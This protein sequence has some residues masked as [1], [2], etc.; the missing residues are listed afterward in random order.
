MLTCALGTGVAVAQESSIIDLEGPQGGS[1]GEVTP[2]EDGSGAAAT[3]PPACGRRS[4]AI[5]QLPWPSASLLAEI[6][7]R[8]LSSSFGCDIAVVGGDLASVASAMGA[9]GQPDIVPELWAA[10]VPEIWNAA[11][12]AQQVRQ[13]GNSYAE[14]VF[15][16][17]FVPDYA[18]ASWPEI[19]TIEGLR[20]RA[21]TLAAGGTRPRFISCPVDWACNLINRNLLAATGLADLVDIVEPGNRFEMDTLIAEGVGRNEAFV[22]YHWQ[23][24]AILAQF[25]FSAVALPAYEPDNFA[26]LARRA[27]ATPQPSGFPP[28]PVIIGLGER[29]YTDAPRV[30]S[31]FQRA[32][33]PLE[34][35]NALLLR[36][37]ETGATTESVA[38]WFLAER[39]EVW[40]GWVGL[41]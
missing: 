12:K 29:V 13:A 11:I 7:G 14:Q 16:G 40:R 28:D 22:M 20:T 25:G 35:M 31:Y 2:N 27:C 32:R 5:A 10:R 3:E 33:L 30:A 38:A 4:L 15:E 18:A 37:N 1:S 6:H 26:C 21:A 9:G 8:I 24:N 34:E 17:W 41:P 19:T 39:E 23:P 36:L